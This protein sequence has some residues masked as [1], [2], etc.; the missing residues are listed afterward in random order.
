[1]KGDAE[2]VCGGPSAEGEDSPSGSESG[3]RS[4]AT[5]IECRVFPE[6]DSLAEAAA[7]AVI[8]LLRGA[9]KERGC[10]F[11]SLSGGSTPEPLYRLLSSPR[12]DE[13]VAWER[14]HLLW[15]DERVVPPDHEAS[16][17]SLVSRSGLLRRN[18]AGV[19][20]MPGEMEPEEA[21]AD[22]E[23]RL[24]ALWPRGDV[25]LDVGL[26][27][28]GSDGHTASLF[29]GAPEVTEAR[30]W[31]V[32]TEKHAGFRRLTLT[33]PVFW[34]SSCL[35][36]LVSGSGKRNALRGVF[37]HD[38]GLPAYLVVQGARRVVWL[39]DQEAGG[40]IEPCR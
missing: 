24:R 7:E 14:I 13:A 30:K 28:L 34:S 12:Y 32:A 25:Q 26:L 16:N 5:R 27:G 35:L 1:M 38:E 3:L 36:F 20:R 4:A 17:F 33:L 6:I 22:Y 10:G 15:G 40:G 37:R 19:H 29:P 21:A 9:V 31:V 8:H 39:V 11:I 23:H 2:E 18:L